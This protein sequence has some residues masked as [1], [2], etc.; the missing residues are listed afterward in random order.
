VR[1]LAVLLAL[2]AVCVVPSTG[3]SPGH[4]PASNGWI[5]F[6]S[7]RSGAGTAGFSLYQLEPMGGRVTRFGE[8]RGRQPAWSP[9]GSLVAYVDTRYRLVVAKAD[10]T[11]L[12]TLTSGRFPVE[13]PAW[14]PDGGRIVFKQTVRRRRNFTD[15]AIARADGSGVI[16]TLEMPYDD[17]QPSWS[18]DGSLIAFSSNRGPGNRVGD[19]EIWVVRPSGRGLRQVTRNDFRDV[20]PSWSPD[21][22]LIAFESGRNQDRFNPELWMMR[23]DGIDERRVQLASDPS[24]FPS[25]S[26]WD[27]SWSPDGN[28]LVYV[29]NATFYPD[30][31]FIV[32]PGG[33][34]KIDLTP[35]TR[36]QDLDPAW[37]PVCSN[38][39]APGG[40]GLRGT[41]ADD[42]LCGFAGNDTLR[43]GTGRDG[44]Y[45]GEGN[46]V[47]RARDGSFDVVGCGAGRDE[48]VADLVDLVGVDCERVRRS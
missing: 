31:V 5:A 43:G 4:T 9:D 41:R 42:R 47:L 18:P 14:S 6:A 22:S 24:G 21:G 35:E 32:R 20:S 19:S 27:P 13:D 30:N 2:A 26:D 16:R 39:G 8:L 40:D 34:D 12:G 36:S 1:R 10:G 37:Q 3:S 15:L 33:Y 45:G 38:P 23:S 46:D 7:D 48:V 17:M 29:S 28:W 44:L 25:W 11:R